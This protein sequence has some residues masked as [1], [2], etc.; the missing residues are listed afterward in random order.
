[1]LG[2][3]VEMQILTPS[4]HLLDQKSLGVRPRNLYLFKLSRWFWDILKFQKCCF[5]PQGLSMLHS[6][7]GRWSEGEK[8][9]DHILRSRMRPWRQLSLSHEKEQW[10]WS[11]DRM[12]EWSHSLVA[13]WRMGKRTIL[14]SECPTS[15]M[16]SIPPQA[17]QL[18]PWAEKDSLKSGNIKPSY[19]PYFITKKAW[20]TSLNIL[21]RI[22]Q[23]PIPCWNS[24]VLVNVT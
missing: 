10:Q 7:R 6:K 20:K 15:S 22:A 12:R 14:S 21:L 18:F 9:L 19:I 16:S 8:I 3:L 23:I 5:I 13:T 24:A 2:Q 1:M 4:S 11:H 17:G